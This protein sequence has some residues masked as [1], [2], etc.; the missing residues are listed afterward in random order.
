[1]RCRESPRR[2]EGNVENKREILFCGH[3]IG[4][5]PGSFEGR[6][7]GIGEGGEEIEGGALFDFVDGGEEGSEGSGDAGGIG[8]D[9]GEHGLV[10]AA[11]DEDCLVEVGWDGDMVEADGF[12]S[13]GFEEGAGDD[14]DGV[15]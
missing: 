5:R 14:G 15:R 2:T 8:E 9:G 1:M 13:G 3:V 11:G 7:F 4:V 6:F 10:R 12:G